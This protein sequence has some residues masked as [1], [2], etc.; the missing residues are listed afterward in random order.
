MFRAIAFSLALGA[1]AS[2]SASVVVSISGGDPTL[3]FALPDHP[4][5]AST[6]DG[7]QLGYRDV[8]GVLD[9][10]AIV[11]PYVT[12]SPGQEW[13]GLYVLVQYHPYS[14]TTPQLYTGPESSPTFSPLSYA[15]SNE[16]TGQDDVLSI[17]SVPEPSSWVTLLLGFGLVGFALRS[18]MIIA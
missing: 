13:G 11:I 15:V 1:A 10:Q 12:F 18:R 8:P 6:L 9:G 2:A 16:A 3:T 4:A 7:V 17:S 14:F 5:P